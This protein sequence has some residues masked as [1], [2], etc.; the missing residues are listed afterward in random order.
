MGK[1][2]LIILGTVLVAWSGSRI[3]GAG[4]GW[5][6]TLRLPAWTPPGAVIGTVWTV[7]F[8]LTA[9]AAIMVL[10]RLTS[11]PRKTCFV[12]ALVL[13]GFLNVGW[14]WVFFGQHLLG[15]AVF[16]AVLLELSVVALI[17]LAWSVSRRAALL[18]VPY[19]GWVAFATYLTYVV[20]NLNP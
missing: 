9:I 11:A 18:L 15:W 16:E 5:Y 10:R 3:T 7:I 17:V 19:A 1:S 2:A 6:R 14:S 4:M 8:V 13:N 20:R 12:T